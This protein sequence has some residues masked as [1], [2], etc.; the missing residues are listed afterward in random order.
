MDGLPSHDGA[1]TTRGALKMKWCRFQNNDA[2]SYGIIEGDDVIAVNGS[3]FEQY[4]RTDERYPLQS[5]KLPGQRHTP[6]PLVG[7][8]LQ[9]L[10]PVQANPQA[11]QL[12]LSL[13]RV[14]QYWSWQQL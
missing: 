10:P 8:A 12:L 3:P 4:R 9:T 14:A 7:S 11:P 1:F 2:A 5:V 13:V 6:R